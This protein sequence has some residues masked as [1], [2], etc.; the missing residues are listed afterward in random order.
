MA[1]KIDSVRLGSPDLLLGTTQGTRL[2]HLIDTG[3]VYIPQALTS[4][5]FLTL[6]GLLNRIAPHAPNPATR[7]DDA[8]ANG[9]RSRSTSSN[10]VA[11]DYQLGLDEL[12]TLARTRTGFAFADLTHELQDAMI[13]LIAT[14]DLTT[15]RLDLSL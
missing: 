15:R 5:Q 7:I 4:S 6:R 11:F 10:F 1:T 13:S 12:D 2:Q 9:N 8:L 3:A 14:R